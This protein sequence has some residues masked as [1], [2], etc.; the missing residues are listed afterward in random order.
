MLTGKKRQI[1][2]PDGSN[3]YRLAENS[4]DSVDWVKVNGFTVST[5]EYSANLAA[6]TVTFSPQT[7]LQ[8][9]TNSVEIQYSKGLGTPA[10]VRQMRFSE[11]YNGL[12]DTRVF[13]Y[14][15][16]SNKAIY[17]GINEFG[18]PDAAYFPVLNLVDVDSENTQITAMVKHFDR[19][20]AYKPDGLWAISYGTITLSDGAV[21]A[22][23]F[24]IPINREIGNEAVGQV[25]LVSNYPVSAYGNALYIW[26]TSSVRDERTARRIS[27]KIECTLSTVELRTAKFFDASY[28]Q[29][30]YIFCGLKTIVYNYGIGAFYVY[31]LGEV[32]A[33]VEVGETI[34]LGFK[35][36]RI[37]AMNGATDD[38]IPIEA[39][40]KSAYSSYENDWRWKYLHGVWLRMTRSQDCVL[41]I[42]CESENDC[43]SE[44]HRLV[45]DGGDSRIRV[46]LPR[47]ASS[48]TCVALR[49]GYAELQ[50]ISEEVSYGGK[51]M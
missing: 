6:G 10:I 24:T 20:L 40:W 41:D 19:L 47:V 37:G 9:G 31:Q 32:V 23:F 35:N 18:E 28:R 49:R 50:S 3:V 16:G 5:V 7:T 12:T 44:V 33:A 8:N 2:S 36:G 29:E 38:G 34:L 1:Y 17:S 21:T 4:I 14:G 11:T 22:A 26:E 15:D 30:L 48:R 46:K 45:G 25:R 51:V 39:T 43:N 27:T 42:W 13:L